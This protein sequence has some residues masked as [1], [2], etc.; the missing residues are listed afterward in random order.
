MAKPSKNEK[1]YSGRMLANSK[2]FSDYQK[3]FLNAILG[4]DE[5]TEQE[6]KTK[7]DAYFGNQREGEK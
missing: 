4:D 3:D 2:L 6:A 5:Y 1:K 7:I